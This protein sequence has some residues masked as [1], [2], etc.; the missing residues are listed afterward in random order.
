VILHDQ[1]QVCFE[2]FLALNPKQIDPNYNIEKAIAYQSSKF[3]IFS[4]DVL[5][6]AN[7]SNFQHAE[8]K[9]VRGMARCFKSSNPRAE[10]AFRSL[11][12]LELGYRTFEK[13][14]VASILKSTGK[15][16]F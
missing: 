2:V 4:S 11:T 3:R 6:E 15:A 14:L 10:L 1:I 16:D 13:M 9:L 7:L 5:P 8:L 12:E